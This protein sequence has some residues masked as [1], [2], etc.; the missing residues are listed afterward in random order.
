VHGVAVTCFC[1][2]LKRERYSLQVRCRSPQDALLCLQASSL[3]IQALVLCIQETLHPPLLVLN[4]LQL[5]GQSWEVHQR[6]QKGG[7]AAVQMLASPSCAAGMPWTSSVT[8]ARASDVLPGLTWD[9]PA[10]ASLLLVADE[11]R[12]ISTW[13][14][15]WRPPPA[16]R[17]PPRRRSL[18]PVLA[19]G[20]RG[21][22]GLMAQGSWQEM[23]L[24]EA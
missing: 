16:S 20:R 12:G 15:S 13:A 1:L 22:L 10:P 11:R 4:A 17:A 18:V 23:L 21:S 8:E 19:G 5:L 24:P 9:G 2:R 6:R 3:R 14:R 7:S